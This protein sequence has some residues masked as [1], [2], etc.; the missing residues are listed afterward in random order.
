MNW[1]YISAQKLESESSKSF[2]VSISPQTKPAGVSLESL[3]LENNSQVPENRAEVG[4]NH[5]ARKA[6]SA[7]LSV[8]KR[9]GAL[10]QPRS[11][12]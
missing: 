9:S 3:E 11:S 5:A 12:K 6:I 10:F 2:A 8:F 1:G 4:Q 7:T